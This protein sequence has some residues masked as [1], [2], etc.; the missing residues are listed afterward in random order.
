[1]KE[2]NENE[3]FLESERYLANMNAQ[4]KKLYVHIAVRDRVMADFIRQDSE[5]HPKVRRVSIKRKHLLITGFVSVLCFYVFFVTHVFS[6]KDQKDKIFANYYETYLIDNKA[7]PRMFFIKNE[8]DKAFQLYKQGNYRE[9]IKQLEGLFK[10]DT[11]RITACFLLGMSYIELQNYSEAI[12]HLAY[13][14]DQND[15]TGKQAEWYLSLCYLK[16]GKTEEATKL[17]TKISSDNGLYKPLA[18]A[19]LNKMK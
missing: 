14:A 7:M 19:I 4:E 11:T 8:Y 13:V 1:M 18:Q 17:F 12:K 2:M 10:S 15:P 6:A 9:A 5:T 16:M 3:R